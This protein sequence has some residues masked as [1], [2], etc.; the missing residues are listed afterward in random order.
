MGWG[1][2][3]RFGSPL[4]SNSWA[5]FLCFGTVHSCHFFYFEIGLLL[6]LSCFGHVRAKTYSELPYRLELCLTF[7]L[8]LSSIIL[9]L[10]RDVKGIVLLLA[11]SGWSV[12]LGWLGLF[13]DSP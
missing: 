7:H 8:G 5:E 13:V 10:H 6:L 2:Q 12:G 4:I 1:A 9:L 3:I 11:C